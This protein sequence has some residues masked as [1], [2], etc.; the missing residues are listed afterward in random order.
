MLYIQNA[1]KEQ[2]ADFTLEYIIPEDGTNYWVDSWVIPANAEH[3]ENAEKFI[4][5]LCR[6]DI[7]KINFDYITYSTPNTGAR[8]LIED[9]AIRN[10]KI[11]FPEPEDLVNCE[12]FRFLG[13]KYD[14]IYNQL[15]R[16]SKIPNSIPLRASRNA[17]LRRA[18][19][20]PI[21]KMSVFQT[22]W[23]T[24]SILSYLYFPCINKSFTEHLA[25]LCQHHKCIRI[26]LM[27]STSDGVRLR[28]GAGTEQHI[29]F[30]LLYRFRS[31][32]LLWNLFR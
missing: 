19:L 12:T 8:E 31:P 30:P 17:C 27:C 20:R 9:P 16:E 10:S 29:P 26:H 7:A 28:T 2:E 5:F 25:R 18:D 23:Q 24:R 21:N 32:G 11:A 6:P 4:N 1:V 15:W 22:M 13:D 14:A 3:K